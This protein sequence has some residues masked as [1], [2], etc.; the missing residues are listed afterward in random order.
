MPARV[1]LVQEACPAAGSVEIGYVTDIEGNINYFD[2]WVEQSGV[3]RYSAPGVL[4]L[5][6][7]LAYFVF[8]GD[9]IDRGPGN[10]R[11]LRRLVALKHSAPERVFFLAGNRDLNKLRMSSELDD[12]DLSRPFTEIPRPHWDANV[13]SLAEYLEALAAERGTIASEL[14][15]R[16][17]RLRWMYKHTLGC[18]DTFEFWRTELAL[19]SDRN[20]NEVGDEEVVAETLASVMPGGL[21][22]QYLELASAAVLLGQTLFVHGA[23]D[24]RNM[25]F[26]PD[27]STR[28]CLPE[29]P[30]GGSYVSTVAEW[31]DGLNGFLTRGLADHARRPEWDAQRSSRGGEQLLALQNREAMWGRSIVSNCYCDGSTITSARAAEERQKLRSSPVTNA[32]QFKLVCSDPRDAKV[33]KWLLGEGV[34]RVV[35]GHK[36]SGDCPSVLSHTYTGVEV[37]S[38]DTS[39]SDIDF[40]DSRGAAVAGLVLRGPFDANHAVVYGKL[41]DGRRHETRLSCLGG[42]AHGSGGDPFVGTEL[43]GGWWVKAR[44]QPDEVGHETQYLCVRGAGRSYTVAFHSAAKLESLSRPLLARTAPSRRS[45]MNSFS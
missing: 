34:R 1:G 19:L 28:F 22:R 20:T 16:A 17:E 9:A 38:V 14:D 24:E 33:A 31:V 32:S 3:L 40:G 4:E 15:C 13:P 41:R 36:P 37:L 44:V 12:A 27:D 23:V 6:H 29:E 18:P 39:Y 43:D 10:L 5:T 25:Q 7:P 11:L 42:D 21:V 45:V 2:K 35:V 26:V 8:G 30:Q